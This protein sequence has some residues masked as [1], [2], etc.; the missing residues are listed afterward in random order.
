MTSESE[1]YISGCKGI[2]ACTEDTIILSIEI[3]NITVHGE[4][5]TMLSYTN[6][7]IYIDGKI[8][9]IE[10]EYRSETEN[11]KHAA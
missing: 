1:L 8:R 4:N 11:D 3:A 5:I 7:E 2:L 9:G 6:G 10:F